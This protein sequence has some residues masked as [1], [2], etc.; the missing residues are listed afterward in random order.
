MLG[1]EIFSSKTSA[2][3]QTFS[4]GDSVAKSPSTV[5]DASFSEASGPKYLH[6]ETPVYPTAAKRIG[7]E[8]RVVLRLTIDEKGSLVNVEVIEKARTGL[9]K[10][11]QMRLND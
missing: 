11:P 6:M 2:G 7:L 4:S 1:G 10:Q 9:S 8:A 5:L 3:S